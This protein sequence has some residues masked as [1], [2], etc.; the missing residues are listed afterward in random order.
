MDFTFEL[1][2]IYNIM[3]FEILKQDKDEVIM[4]LNYMVEK[5]ESAHAYSP[6]VA[7]ND[8]EESAAFWA[9]L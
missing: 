6:A 1:S 7:R 9:A 2:K 5:S 8:R 3:P 4:L